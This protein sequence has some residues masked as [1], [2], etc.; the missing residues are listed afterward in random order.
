MLPLMVPRILQHNRD[1]LG[2]APEQQGQRTFQA[3]S[4]APS[5]FLRATC[6]VKNLISQNQD[7][8]IPKIHTVTV[9]S[10]ALGDH[11]LLMSNRIQPCALSASMS[12]PVGDIAPFSWYDGCWKYVTNSGGGYALAKPCQT[13]C[14]GWKNSCVN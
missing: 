6:R 2:P 5:T 1:S 7:N 4:D 3:T 11:V 12:T 10:I 8:Q 9:L 13:F 14:E